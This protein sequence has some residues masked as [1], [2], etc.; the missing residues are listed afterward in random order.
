MIQ[1]VDVI[2]VKDL[3]SV[4]VTQM[5]ANKGFPEVIVSV[6]QLIAWLLIHI[7]R[8]E[9]R[10]SLR[11]GKKKEI[12]MQKA[13]IYFGM[14]FSGFLDSVRSLISI[15]AKNTQLQKLH[16]SQGLERL[17]TW[18]VLPKVELSLSITSL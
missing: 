5:I 7:S 6:T 3:R 13:T 4:E 18:S 10:K 1:I 9:T 12:L 14:A 17:K 8:K 11:M 16:K 15:P 2:D